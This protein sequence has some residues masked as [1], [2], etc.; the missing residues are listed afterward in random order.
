MSSSSQPLSGN[1]ITPLL[2]SSLNSLITNVILDSDAADSSLLVQTGGASSLYID[3][4]ANVGI[5]TT[6]PGT[7]LEVASA[8]GSCLRLRYGATSALS[9]IF[10]NSSGFLSLNTSGGEVNTNGDFNITAHNGS[11]TGLKLGGTIVS[12]TAA[13][14]NFTSVAA[15]TAAA[16]KAVVLDSSRNITNINALTASQLTGTLQTASQPNITSVGTLPTLTVGDLTV[17]GNLIL[18]SGNVTTALG[19]ISGVTPGTAAPSKALILDSSS[20]IS[21]IASLGTTSISIGG[22]TIGATQSGYITGITTGT[23]TASKA[24]V[25]DSSRN[26]ININ[27]LTASQLTGTLQTAAQTNIT[28]V[29]TL[30]SLTSSGAIAFTS[31]T[32]ASSSSSGGALTVSGGLAVALSAYIGSNLTVGGNLTVNGTTTTVNATTVSVKDNI[33]LLNSSPSGSYDGGMLVQRYQTI[34]NTGAGDVVADTAKESTTVS[35]ATSSTIVL[36][37]GNASDSYYNGWW[38]KVGSDVRLITSYVASS[39]TITVSTTFSSTPSNGLS[40]SLYNKGN[41]ALIWNEANK[42]FAATFAATDS[43]TTLTTIDYASIKVA[44]LS[45]LNPITTTDATESSST[46]TGSIITSG[47]VGIAKALRVGNGIYGTIQTASQTNI[48]AIGTLST[49]TISSSIT[50]GGTTFGSTEVGYLTSITAGTASASK[51][52]VLDS[53]LNITGINSISATSLTVNGSTLDTTSLGY[54]TSITPGTASASKAL[55]LNSSSNISGINSLGTTTLVLGGNTLGA[56][57]SGYL[58]SITA[59]TAS[60]SKALVLDSSSNIAGINAIV[61]RDTATAAVSFPTLLQ[62][63]LSSGTAAVG[64]GTGLKFNAPT[65]TGTSVSYSRIDGVATDVTNG[66]H[67]GKLDF[68]N[69]FNAAFVKAMTLS[70]SGAST[71][72]LVING[73]GSIT[74]TS[75]VLGGNTLGATESGYLT[76]IT[77]GTASASK[78]LVVDSSSNISGINSLGTTTLVLGGNT[79]GTTESGYL[80]SI[81][82]GTASAS[83][84]LVVDSNKDIISIRNV[85]MFGSLTNTITTAST[86]NSTGALILSGGIGLNNTADAS[87]ITN[88]GTITSAGG[89]SIAKKLYVGSTLTQGGT[90]LSSSAWGTTGIQSAYI[91]TSFTDSSTAGSGTA[92]NAVFNSFAQPTLLATNTSVTTTNAMTVYIANAPVASTNQTIT[93]A[94]ALYVA[95]GMAF[96]GGSVSMNG[97][98]FTSTQAGYLTPITA[99]TASASKALVLDSSSNITSI[100][101][102]G[103]TTLVLGGS[104]LGATQAGYLTSITPG[105][106]SASKAL[107]LDSSLNIAGINSISTT[108][109]TVNGTSITGS[110]LTYVSGITPGTATASKALV[111]DSSTNITGINSLGT[112]TLVLGGNNLGATESGYLTFITAGTA[113]AGKALVVNGSTNISGINSVS[114]TTLVLGGNSLSATESG[115]LTSITAGTASASKALVVDSNKDIASIRNVSMT[116]TLS[117]GTTISHSST[118]TNTLATATTSNST[119][120]LILSGGIG[121]SLTTDASSSTNGGTLSTAGGAAIAKTLYVGT[122]INT[123]KISLTDTNVSQL[124][125]TN[126]SASST[127]NATFTNDTGR[128]FDMGV[129]GSTATT[130]ANFYIYDTT[131]TAFRLTMD[132]SGT[133]TLNGSI[134]ISSAGILTIPNSTASTTNA[135]GAIVSSGGIGINLTTDASSITNGGTLS[136]AGGAAIAKKLY[137]GSTLTQGG[138]ATSA[139]AWGTTGVQTAHIATSFTDASTS[140]SGIATN[141][142]FNSFAQPTLLAASNTVTTTNAMTVYI[143]NAPTAGAN[144]TITNAYALYVAAGTAFFGGNLSLNGTVFTS[145]QATFLSGITA[146]TASASKALVVDA[147]TNI[148][149]INSIGTTLLV[150]GATTISETEIAALDAVTAGTASAS[151]ALIVDTNKDIAAI[152]NVS[153]TGS[154]TNT[155]T[156]VSTS[157]STGALILSG[158]IGISLATDATSSTNGGTISTAGGLAVAKKIFAG[159]DITTA[160]L[161]Q[162][163]IAGTGLKHTDGTITL[164]SVVNSGTDASN[165]YIGTSSNHGLILQTNGSARL[166]I[167]NT[168]VVSVS[169]TTASTSSSTGSVVLTGGLGISLSTDASS[170]TNGGALTVA[171]GVAI[172]K[173]LY[174][175]TTLTQ[176]G[177]AISSS[178]WGTTGIQTAYMATNFTDSSTASSGTVANAV[179]NSFAQPSLLATNASVTTTNAMTIYIA[180]APAASTNQ[181]ITNAYALY[182]AAGKSAFGGLVSINN[183]ASPSFNIDMGSP[184]TPPAMAISM[185]A[186]TRGFGASTSALDYYSD[187]SHKW[188]FSASAQSGAFNTAPSGTNTMTLTSGGNWSIAGTGTISSTTDATSSTAGGACTI[189]G[190]AGIAKALYVGSNTFLGTGSYGTL[191]VGTSTDTGTNRFI[192]CLYS[193]MGAGAPYYI[194]LGQATSTNNQAELSF[195]YTSSGS[196]SNKFEIGFFGSASRWIVLLASGNLSINGTNDATSSVSGGACT[197]AGGLAVAKKLYV[198]GPFTQ[199]GTG[200]TTSAWGTTGIQSAYVATNYTDSSTAGSGTAVNAVFNS[201]AQSTLLATNSSVTTTNAITV[202]IANAPAAGTNQTITNAYALYVAAGTS[203]FGGAV[204]ITNTTTSTSSSTGSLLLSGGIGLSNTTDASSSTN[205]GTITTA[206]GCAI[207]KTL[208]V[209]TAINTKK[210]TLTDTNSNLLVL[211]NTASG[212]LANILFTNDVPNS[213]ELGLRGSAAGPNNGSFYIYDNTNASFRMVMSVSTGSITFNSGATFSS[214][215]NLSITNTTGSTSNSTG[216]ITLS[217]GLGISLSTDAS[218]VTNGGTITTAGGVAIAKKLYVGTTFTQGGTALSASA[219]GTTGIQTAHVATSFTDSSTAGSGTATNATFHSF[220]QPTLLATNTSVTTTNAMTMYIANAPTASTN[221]TITNSYALYVAAGSSLFGGNVFM[222]TSSYGTLCI[223]TSTDINNGRAISC[224]YSSMA[225]SASYYITIGQSATT[226]NQAELSFSYAGSS[227]TSN[228]FE[229]GFFGGT[230]LLSLAASGNLS[231]TGTTDATSSSSGGACTIA[232]GCAIAKKLYVGTDTTTTRNTI[233]TGAGVHAYGF[234]ST[235]LSS[236]GGGAH[237]HFGSSTASFIGYN[238]SNSTYTDVAL[239]SSFTITASGLCGIGGTATYPLDIL[240]TVTGSLSGGYGYLAQSGSSTGSGTGSAAVSLRCTGRI[241]ATE[242]DCQSDVRIKKDIRDV[243]VDEAMAF[244]TKVIPVHYTMRRTEEKSYGYIAQQLLKVDDQRYNDL[245]E[246]HKYDQP[247]DEVID[248]DGFVSPKDHILTVNYLKAIPLLHKCI[249]HQ[250]DQIEQLKEVLRRNGLLNE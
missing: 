194:T 246:C 230:R 62:H 157:N 21:G 142:V 231:L 81:T 145:A 121:I 239:G 27:A 34:N 200:L 71:S 106:A 228:K 193:S 63:N 95:A 120:A 189:S 232:G 25:V 2:R 30:T 118:Y 217:G 161:L 168:G 124:T 149:G 235:G 129:R 212:T 103:T 64:I 104:T 247:I 12:A 23:A 42:Q 226:N 31:T 41:A 198:G 58:T 40:V 141:A 176:G 14:L 204:S 76:S 48:T 146:G 43:S 18:S 186:G 6:S 52:L 101:S 224:L 96:F 15:G 22:N 119:G 61:A 167:N 233:S 178:S 153:M 155:L 229:I 202:Y 32:D 110:S 107:V 174:I 206:G 112:T 90:A 10:M 223:G 99:G 24:L 175:G 127:A 116:G 195:T 134:T 11:T 17:N 203:L 92:T 66:S 74:T 59:G 131:N 56:T 213:F 180:N 69:V 143:A 169:N 50:L 205:G 159:S 105:T 53:S 241:F 88:G 243:D 35:S 215:G 172:A 148:T 125:I 139:N 199:G 46:S 225:T 248:D 38:V 82:A 137:V 187:G 26:I 33:I 132:T 91:A 236:F 249:Q 123:K 80:T 165:A 237:M 158:G 51:A 164:V 210:T 114:T 128:S 171:G 221:Q 8:N 16:S 7:Q 49:A 250:Q 208:Y 138:T 185:Y 191:C 242:V 68:Y 244:M 190:G 36:T 136:T 9:N 245:I 220:A 126:S 144:Q 184:A 219:W 227:S 44:G 147:S 177:T 4:Y 1:T 93:N 151:K 133:I 214:A 83:K 77:A 216:V 179:F 135:T 166:T 86:S 117:G 55:V 45:A 94:Y 156:T 108:L 70:T 140:A 13:Q 29:G 163:T 54:L 240:N 201:F 98:L 87:S 115:Y 78:V 211:N 154:I 182:V 37:A 113:S 89:A 100:N 84:V 28:S 122:A 197:I 102:L 39:K 238:Y 72:S 67:A 234:D 188:F 207:A 65:A 130:P 5:N 60:A 47:G 73:T 162:T 109:L 209:G 218:S 97:T 57:E 111:V 85:S 20:N 183:A 181:T 152:R 150:V 3:K 19:Y 160:G 170:I 75:I 79:L 192:S 222:G 196:S 173:K